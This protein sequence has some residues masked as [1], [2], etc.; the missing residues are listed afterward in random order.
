MET[1]QLH[2]NPARLHAQATETRFTSR[3][4]RGSFG[5]VRLVAETI[6]SVVDT[7]IQK[8]TNAFVAITDLWQVKAGRVSCRAESSL[9]FK[10]RNAI[11]KADEDMK[12]DG[13]QIHLG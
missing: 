8:A 4:L 12:I 11:L 9:H 5:S 6:E 13:D 3:T 10:S 7:V 1:P 2:L